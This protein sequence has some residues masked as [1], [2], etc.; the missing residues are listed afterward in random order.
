M[1]KKQKKNNN[2]KKDIPITNFQN[3]TNSFSNLFDNVESLLAS[4]NRKQKQLNLPDN[5]ENHYI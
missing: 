4:G 5:T 3:I 2:I 1:K